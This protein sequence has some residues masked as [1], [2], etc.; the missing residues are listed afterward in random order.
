M[1]VVVVV[2]VCQLLL[3]VMLLKCGAKVVAEAV[4]VAAELDH[5]VAKEALMVG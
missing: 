5:T 1:Q 4:A 2:Y 3:R